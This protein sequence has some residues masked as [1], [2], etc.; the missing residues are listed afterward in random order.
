MGF[1]VTHRYEVEVFETQ[2]V[3]AST[4]RCDVGRAPELARVTVPCGSSSF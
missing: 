1:R 2:V 4:E 3:H